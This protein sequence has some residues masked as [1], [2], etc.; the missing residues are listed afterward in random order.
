[1]LSQLAE[2][3]VRFIERAVNALGAPGIALIA[4]LENLFP[5]TP[6]EILYPLA[7]KLASEGR[8]TLPAIIISGVTGSLIGAVCYYLLGYHLGEKRIRSF[9]SNY[10]TLHV[11]ALSIR[12][13]RVED[14]D[15]SLRLFRQYGSAVVFVGRLVPLVHGIVSLPA[16]ITHMN[17]ILFLVYTGLGATLWIAPLAIFGWWLGSHWA[18]VLHW[19]DVYNNLLLLLIAL[20]MVY[21]F[22]RRLRPH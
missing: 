17:M 3:F 18:L 12:L 20:F 16:G 4:L 22:Y 15:K 21:Y 14:Y 19:L 7:G 6:S 8:I 10:G 9:I 1:M 2:T 13:L 11:F 5:P